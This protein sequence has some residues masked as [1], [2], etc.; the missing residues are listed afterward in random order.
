MVD[1][2]STEDMQT[3]ERAAIEE[4]FERGNETSPST[5]TEL[6]NPNPKP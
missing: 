6:R 4:W 3:Y 2:V 5:G 1:P